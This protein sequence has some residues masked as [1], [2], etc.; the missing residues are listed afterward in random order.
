[1][2]LRGLRSLHRRGPE[3]Y[4]N[5]RQHHCESRFPVHHCIPSSNRCR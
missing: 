1:L 2:V 3:Q 4:P 5:P